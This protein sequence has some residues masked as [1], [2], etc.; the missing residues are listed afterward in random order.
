MKTD[1]LEAHLAECL[2]DGGRIGDLRARVESKFPDNPALNAL[3]GVALARM[4]LSEFYDFLKSEDGANGESKESMA[5]QV[6]NHRY[7]D[8]WAEYISNRRLTAEALIDS[9]AELRA[10]LSRKLGQ[11]NRALL[12]ELSRRKGYAAMAPIGDFL[13]DL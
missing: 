11:L 4:L 8:L 7:V 5:H 6:H 12:D 3:M 2:P 13:R 9:K 1:E 10:I